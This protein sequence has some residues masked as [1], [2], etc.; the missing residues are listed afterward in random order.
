MKI[1]IWERV[2]MVTDSYHHEGG[3]AIIAKD[4]NRAIETGLEN[5]P[6]EHL[7]RSGKLENIKT[8]RYEEYSIKSDEE[9]IFI[10][11]DAGCC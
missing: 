3:V 4:I 9:K 2:D 1:F 8:A 5:F 7:E 6:K 10:F 11:P